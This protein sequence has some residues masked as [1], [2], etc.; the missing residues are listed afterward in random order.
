MNNSKNQQFHLLAR[1]IHI[2]DDQLL[3]CQADGKPHTFLPGGH[4][5]FGESIPDALRREFQEE[6]HRTPTIQSYL[7]TV[8]H[9]WPRNGLQHEVNHLF[10]IDLP[11]VTPE[12]ES[13]SKEG[14]LTFL[15]SPIDEL[16]EYQLEPQPVIDVLQQDATESPLWE[17][18]IDKKTET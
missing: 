12:V 17:S 7:G 15:W 9:T 14:H 3:I 8:E 18:T 2:V 1:A 6:M 5:E 4:V 10:R 11:E 16:S 13:L